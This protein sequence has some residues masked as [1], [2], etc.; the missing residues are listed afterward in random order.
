MLLY[1]LL[2]PLVT[3][4]SGPSCIAEGDGTWLDLLARFVL[5]CS[6][7]SL[8]P[9]APA[10]GRLMLGKQR[11]E[12]ALAFAALPVRAV[13]CLHAIREVF[14]DNDRS[15]GISSIMNNA[16]KLGWRLHACADSAQQSVTVETASDRADDAAAD[17][18]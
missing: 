8:A 16:W 15:P 1:L 12:L 5:I 9:V 13:K 2:V 7:G 3:V 14:S 18:P 6:A 11:V 4:G 10:L 17:E